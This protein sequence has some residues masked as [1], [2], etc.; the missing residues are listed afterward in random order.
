[1]PMSHSAE[2]TKKA[3]ALLP[4]QNAK[5]PT[6]LFDHTAGENW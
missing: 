3:V 1:M 6:I 5:C 4:E 2:A